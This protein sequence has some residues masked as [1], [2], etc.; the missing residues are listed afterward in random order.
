MTGKY[1]II[2]GSNTGIG[3]SRII[4]II[5][6]NSFLSNEGYET[7]KELLNMNATVVLACR[8]KEKANQARETLLKDI[9]VASSKVNYFK[10]SLIYF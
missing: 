2:T 5:F 7:A 10:I 3:K 6:L 1:Y 4:F 9:N 8:S